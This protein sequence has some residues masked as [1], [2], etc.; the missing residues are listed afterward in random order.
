MKRMKPR[1]GTDK[2]DVFGKKREAALLAITLFLISC[3]L[4]AQGNINLSDPIVRIEKVNQ[5]AQQSMERKI[6]AWQI[7]QNQG[8]SPKGKIGDK[9][10]DLMAVEDGIV[11]VYT[12]TNVNSAISSGVDLIRNTAPYNLNGSGLTAGVWD[13]GAVRPTHQEFGSRVIVRDGASNSNHSTHVGG[14]IGAAGVVANALGMAPRVNI[15]SYEWTSDTAE[16]TSRAMSYPQEPGTIQVSNH[17]YSYISGWESSFSPPRWYGT[18]GNRESDNFGI[19]NSYTVEWDSLCYNAPYFLP[20]KSAGNDRNDNAPSNGTTFSYFN[21]VFWTTKSYDP[22]SDP[23]DDGWDNGGYDTISMVGNAKNIVTVG[24]VSDAVS[25]GVR[26]VSAASIASFSNWGPTDDGRIKPDIVANGI[27]LYSCSASSNTSY[28]TFSGTSM[29]SP[30]AAGAAMLLVDHYNQLHPGQSIRASTLKGL[31][32]H[33]ADDLGNSGPDYSYG[34]G[35]INVKAAADLMFEETIVEEV[36]DAAEPGDVF[37]VN[38]D[39]ISPIWVTVCWTD[40]PASAL[41]GLDNTSPRLI[42]D[43]DLRIIGPGGSPTYYPYVLDPVNPSVTATTGDNILD[44]V[45]QVYISAPTEGTYTIEITHKDTLTNNEQ[46]YSL[47]SSLSMG[48]EPPVAQSFDVNTIAN[49]NVAIDLIASDDG[50]PDP[51]GNMTYIITSLPID[52]NLV[53]ANTIDVITS[54]PYSLTDF[55]KQVIYQPDVNF[56]GQDEFAYKVN[57]GGTAPT[58]GDSGAAT[59][60]ITVVE[61]PV[62]F[63]QDFEN[64]LGIF[65]IDN[66]FGAGDGL[67]HLTTSC[68]SLSGIHSQPSSLY[69]GLDNQCNYDAKKPPDGTEGIVVSEQISL[70]TAK[71]PIILHF[72]YF[73]Q[74]EAQASSGQDVAEVQISQNNGPFVVLASNSDSTL[75]DPSS[76]WEYKEIDISNF[77]DSKIRLL[78]SFRTGNHKDNKHAGFYIDDVEIIGA[79]TGDFE[80]DGNVDGLDYA[81]FALAWLT[82]E[83]DQKYNPLFDISEPSDGF[84][85]ENDLDVFIKNWLE[86]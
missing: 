69:Y 16:M 53:D 77:A 78:F 31:L 60:S 33:T 64:G 12:T 74:T 80:P 48:E 56:L 72:N 22:A 83:G 68:E 17:S 86:D 38:S 23:Y 34:W 40:P 71:P 7:A 57:D 43:L 50:E 67:W 9:L 79:I 66:S 19:Y 73:L 26:N 59:V 11:Y 30:S 8:W 6:V 44:N 82:G 47:I 65:S 28:T 70:I 45:E 4:Y 2:F 76:G 41:T 75:N 42:N 39:G 37:Y 29:S 27:G 10:Y 85:D 54:V 3:R 84:I 1:K 49:T 36:V 20:F 24:A 13:G 61:Q 46:Y 32:I 62:D 52:G 35:L 51:P 5:L 55:G 18:W 81:L 14:T 25:G 15:D 21:G 58:G 63:Y